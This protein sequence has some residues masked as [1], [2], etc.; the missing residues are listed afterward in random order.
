MRFEQARVSGDR[1]GTS[2]AI[3]VEANRAYVIAQIALPTIGLALSGWALR[4][5][6][7]VLAVVAGA[8]V[9]LAA[10]A[11][12]VRVGLGRLLGAPWVIADRDGIAGHNV[13]GVSRYP[14]SEVVQVLWLRMPRS[15]GGAFASYT[16]VKVIP[17]DQAGS[18]YGA[19]NPHVIAT[20]WFLGNR[21]RSSEIGHAFLGVCEHYGATTRFVVGSERES[22]PEPGSAP[23]TW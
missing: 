10:G 17:R 6:S 2:P 16:I 22:G 20:L 4:S 3:R 23:P 9:L 11:L 18:S 5:S 14:W 1:V 21:R 19:I 7:I 15:P 12:V 8:V 13:R